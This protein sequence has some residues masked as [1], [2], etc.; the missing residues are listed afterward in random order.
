MAEIRRKLE[1]GQKLVP[2]PCELTAEE[3]RQF[4][5]LAGGMG[6]GRTVV[7]LMEERTR[8]MENRRMLVKLLDECLNGASP[9]KIAEAAAATKSA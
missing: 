9:G 2:L 7:W 3:K 1:K 6:Y 8:L 5:E 4:L